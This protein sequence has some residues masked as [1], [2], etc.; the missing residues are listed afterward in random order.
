MSIHH[1]HI[2]V[3]HTGRRLLPR[4]QQAGTGRRLL[5]VV[6]MTVYSGQATA[7]GRGWSTAPHMSLLLL[8]RR[9]RVQ[10]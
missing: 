6:P 9:G 3:A 7:V 2:W 8:A 1:D 4:R 10:C 5:G